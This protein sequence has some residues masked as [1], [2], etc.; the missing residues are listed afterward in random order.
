[1]FY[2]IIIPVYNR[3]EEIKELLESLTKQTYSNFEI[4]I[5]EDGSERKSKKVVESFSKSLEIKYYYKK[6]SGQGFSRNYGFDRASGDYFV[7]FD[8]D[9][10]IPEHYFETVN[11]FLTKNKNV[12]CWGGPDKAHPSFTY[13]QKAINFSMTSFLTT[14]GIR[15]LKKNLGGFHPR[16]FNMGI[17]REVYEKTGGYKITRMGE[18]LEF[19]MRI[20]RSGFTT[21]LI[22]NAFVYHKRRTNLNQFFWQLHFFGRARINIRRFYPDEVKLVHLF[23]TFFLI[24]LVASLLFIIFEIDPFNLLILPYLL[25]ATLLFVFALMKEKNIIV[26]CLSIVT[27]FTQLIA[28]SLG[29]LT[30]LKNDMLKNRE[31]LPV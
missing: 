15:G 17:S 28:Y 25:Y 26:A 31:K 20:I 7:V 13:L 21:A 12:D 6:N 4:L 1:M 19:T 22:E 24:G 5:I 3:P 23:P 2:S 8:S 30:E 16:S 10:I 27:G 11:H 14:G 18:D 29:F 9:C